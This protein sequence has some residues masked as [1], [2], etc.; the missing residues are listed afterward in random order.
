MTFSLNRIM[1]FVHNVE[2]LKRFY[3]ENFHFELKEEIKDEWVVL[4]SGDCELALHRSGLPS[5]ANRDPNAT[6]NVKLIFETT[7][8]LPQLRETFLRKNIH[9][10][11][12]KTFPGFPNPSCDGQDPEGNVFQLVQTSPQPKNTSTQIIP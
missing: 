11:E 9:M 6:N 2:L 12:I 3:Q 10:R 4:Q 7:T 8:G 1:L 5:E